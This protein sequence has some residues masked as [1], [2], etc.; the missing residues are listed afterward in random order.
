MGLTTNVGRQE[1]EDGEDEPDNPMAVLANIGV[2]AIVAA[3]QNAGERVIVFVNDEESGSIVAHGYTSNGDIM[4]DLLAN[5][6]AFAKTCGLDL[7]TIIADKPIGGQ[8]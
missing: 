2:K 6:E 4:L 7:Q 1:W 5:L 3:E 8:G